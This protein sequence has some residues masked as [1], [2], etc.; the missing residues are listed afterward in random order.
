MGRGS[1]EATLHLLDA[2]ATS[3]E[4]GWGWVV[5]AAVAAAALVGVIATGVLRRENWLKDEVAGDAARRAET[6][7][8]A[9]IDRHAGDIETLR[10]AIDAEP[11]RL[12][13]HSLA[14]SGALNSARLRMQ[15]L[16]SAITPRLDALERQQNEIKRQYQAMEGQLA[17][18]RA[19]QDRFADAV[20][21]LPPQDGVW[22][23]R[24]YRR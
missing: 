24:H 14:H 1:A 12:S 19:R 22:D 16:E 2:A 15:A 21:Q 11:P 3:P 10:S 7:L 23:V 20:A 18:L 17:E 9:E 5:V 8:R 6:E 4:G 13:E